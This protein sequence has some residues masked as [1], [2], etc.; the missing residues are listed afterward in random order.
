MKT[1]PKISKA[2]RVRKPVR[3]VAHLVP[4]CNGKTSGI[5]RWFTPFG[6]SRQSN[7]SLGFC[8]PANK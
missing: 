7:I 5:E 4:A 3:N 2:N 8:F 6:D 1:A